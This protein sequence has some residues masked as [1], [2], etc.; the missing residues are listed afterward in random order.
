MSGLDVVVEGEALSETDTAE[1]A[2]I[3]EA[4]EAKYG[5]HFTAPS[6]TWFGLGDAMRSGEALVFRVAPPRIFAFAKGTQYSQTR[7]RFS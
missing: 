4:F 1:L 6:G 7:Y 5:A 3:A 2:S